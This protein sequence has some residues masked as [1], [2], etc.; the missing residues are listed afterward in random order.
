MSKKT[1]II[2]ITIIALIFIS[3]GVYLWWENNEKTPRTYS[4]VFNPPIDPNLEPE[5]HKE[6][7]EKIQKTVHFPVLYPKTM[8][9]GWKLVSVDA[10][11]GSKMEGGKYYGINTIT[12]EQRDKKLEIKEG[13]VD[14]GLVNDIGE[15]ILPDGKKGWLWQSGNKL[16][17]TTYKNDRPPLATDYC[18][19][20]V[21]EN[22]SQE[23]FLKL[24]ESLSLT[25]IQ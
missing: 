25:E 22:I 18:Y 11:E 8:P 7:Y 1:T 14:I 20:I 17:L 21:G 9:E 24:A 5:K 4:E 23:E 15:V 12:Y 16:G 2:L 19:F 6:V 10:T 13:L 3:G